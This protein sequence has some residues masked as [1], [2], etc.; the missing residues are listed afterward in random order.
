M[1]KNIITSL[2]IS[3]ICIG[4]YHFYL[5]KKHD[6]LAPRVKGIY[7]INVNEAL[8]IVKRKILE[9]TL[10]GKDVNV[11]KEMQKI[12]DAL[13]KISKKVPEGYILLPEDIVLGGKRKEINILNGKIS[14]KDQFEKELI[15][16][17]KG[18]VQE[19]K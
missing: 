1:V 14:E 17:N 2:L 4:G 15:K 5:V 10:Q 13:D 16:R 11:D 8:D 6:L 18:N 19:K 3:L 7:T 12:Q 9:N